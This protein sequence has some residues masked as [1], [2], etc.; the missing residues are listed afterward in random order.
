MRMRA[1]RDPEY[2]QLLSDLRWGRLTDAQIAAL[3]TRVLGQVTTHSPS[4]ERFYRPVV[5]ST[6]ELR[7]AINRDMM[8]EAAQR[9]NLPVYECLAA[10]PERSKPILEHIVNLNDDQTQRIPIK[11]AFYIGMPVMI[12]RKHPQLLEA[13]VI[14]NGVLGTVIGF[15]PPADSL[16]FR[17]A[18]VLGVTVKTFKQQPKLLLIKI[19]SSTKTLVNGF[20]SGVIGLPPLRTPVQLPQIP[21]L[22]QASLT[23]QQFAAVSAFA[24]TTEKLQGQ[25][26]HDGI[27]VTRL[28]RQ[29][30]MPPQTLYVALSR[31]LSLDGVTLTEPITREYLKKFKPNRATANEMKR[32]INLVS[33]PPYITLAQVAEFEGW[34]AKQAI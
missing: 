33:L 13:N 3:N 28:E 14:A 30:G 31:S 16:T 7:C 10:P 26:C 23:M 1:K 20:P 9:L 27:V 32:L 17:T 6:N 4:N 2:T 5:V 11:L 8:F 24:C 19:S 29:K 21:N 18:K 15:A 22:H 34:K 12:T 25:T